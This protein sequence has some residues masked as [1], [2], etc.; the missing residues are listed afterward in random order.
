MPEQTERANVEAALLQV[1]RDQKIQMN[2]GGV[3]TIQQN[4]DLC[5]SPK[6]NV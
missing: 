1:S 2:I 5:S 6:F 4:L 3:K